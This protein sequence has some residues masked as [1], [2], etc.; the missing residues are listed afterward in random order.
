[1]DVERGPPARKRQPVEDVSISIRE[2]E[3]RTTCEHAAARG[4]GIDGSL[5]GCRQV[6][7]RRIRTGVDHY[8]VIWSD[9][10]IVE[11]ILHGRF[12]C[13]RT[14]AI[15]VIVAGRQGVVAVGRTAVIDVEHARVTC[16]AGRDLQLVFGGV[17]IGRRNVDVIR[18][19]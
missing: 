11:D 3:S 19:R 12:R 6:R 9:V 7:A 4:T 1:M 15:V 18:T 17:V 13:R 16:H 8:Q 10:V 14:Q 5:I 2:I